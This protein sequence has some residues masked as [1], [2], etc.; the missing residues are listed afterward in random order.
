MQAF[1]FRMKSG[2]RGW[3]RIVEAVISLLLITGVLLVL[4]SKGYLKKEDFSS[5]IYSSQLAL[6]REIQLDE[7]L[8]TQILETDLS[9]GP[10]SWDNPAFPQDVKNKINE[11]KPEHL[12][13]TAKICLLDK[14]CALDNYPT[15]DVYVQSVAITATLQKYDPKQL[16]LF[17]WEK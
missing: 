7:N 10:V 13:C 11:R 4:I 5:E 17:C 9:N 8:R 16:K 14:I 6:L 3:V 12:E 15:K 1:N 2:K